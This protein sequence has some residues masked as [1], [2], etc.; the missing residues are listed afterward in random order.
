MENSWRYSPRRNLIFFLTM[1]VNRRL[2]DGTRRAEEVT[3]KSQIYVNIFGQKLT[4]ICA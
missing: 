1:N 4:K 2:S 3:N